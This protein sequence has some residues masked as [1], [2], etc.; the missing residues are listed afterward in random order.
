[1]Q[2]SDRVNNINWSPGPVQNK[3]GTPNKYEA[4]WSD[5]GKTYIITVGIPSGLSHEYVKNI[6]EEQF[7]EFKVKDMDMLAKNKF[8]YDPLK[9][10][11]AADGKTE[12]TLKRIESYFEGLTGWITGMFSPVKE[13]EFTIEAEVVPN[14]HFEPLPVEMIVS[15]LK[16]LSIKEILC[17]RRVD[18]RF[19]D[20][21]GDVLAKKISDENI[22]LAE[23][24]LKGN[25]KILAF[26]NSL[27]SENRMRIKQ[28]NLWETGVD[29]RFLARLSSLTPNLQCLNLAG[30]FLI[31]RRG[32]KHLAPLIQLQNLNLA[33][34]LFINDAGLKNLTSLTQLRNLNLTRCLITGVGLQHLASLTELQGLHLANCHNINKGSLQHLTSLTKLQNLK[35]LGCDKITDEDLNYLA[36]LTKLQEL[37]ISGCHKITDKGLAHLTSLTQLRI[38]NLEGCPFITVKAERKLKSFIPGLTVITLQIY[39]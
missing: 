27:S 9:N 11:S 31:T 30:C 20:L 39:I 14:S 19:R 26:L 2:P 1:M 35:L 33:G 22:S 16:K 28:L 5:G 38:L 24:G 23:L 29:D 18:R 6:I 13:S 37:W 15:V 34:C 7:K 36:S 8:S 12:I 10:D 4:T 17:M 25:A 3:D 32:L 21:G